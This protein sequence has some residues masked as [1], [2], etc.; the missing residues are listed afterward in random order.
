MQSIQTYDVVLV[1]AG[2][3]SATLGALLHELDPKIT[4]WIYESQDGIASESSDVM[5]NA[6]TGHSAFCELNYTPQASDGSIDISKALTIV[7]QFEVS[8]QFWSTL[9]QK[10]YFSTPHSYINAIPHCSVV[11]G[12]KD[13]EFL[14]TRYEALQKNH[15]FHGMEYSED[16]AL[17]STW[18]PLI[19]KNRDLSTPIAATHMSIGTDIDFGSLTR[20]MISHLTISD[21][22]YMHN[23]HRVVD[24]R[25]QSDG[26]RHISVHDTIANTTH[27]VRAPFVFIGAG[28]WALP[29]LQKSGIAE[30]KWFWWFPVS[31]QRLVCNNPEI[32]EQHYAKV[33]GKAALGAP[34]MSVPHLDTRIIDGKKALLF[35]PYAWFTTKFLKKWSFLDLPKSIKYHNMIAMIAAGAHNIPLTTYLIN[36]VRQ[37]SDDRL[38]A[39]REYMPDAHKDDRDLIEAGYRVQ[40]IAPDAKHWGKLQFGTEVI[41][42]ADKSFSTLL[43]ASPW[44]ST[45]VSIMVEIVEKCFP[46]YID[47]ITD[48]IPSYGTSLGDNNNLLGTIRKRTHTTLG[49]L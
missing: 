13:V 19:T 12:K 37:S 3:M 23:N 26:L 39:L 33:Y 36:Q 31:G 32:I 8:K 44:A 28:G 1:W 29:L 22:V 11:F 30:R 2:I 16:P 4:V 5:N 43:G 45:S 18:M 25:K 9:T 17:I 7:E 35:G 46:Q 14:K 20:Q 6:W 24:L 49:L 48:I 47:R 41:V 15:L 27:I 42:S 40:I 34:P 21:H 10:W 38:A